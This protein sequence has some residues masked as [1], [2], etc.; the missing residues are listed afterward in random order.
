VPQTTLGGAIRY[1]LAD[2]PTKKAVVKAEPKVEY[3]VEPE[4]QVEKKKKSF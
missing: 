3:Q 2:E 1:T 4:K